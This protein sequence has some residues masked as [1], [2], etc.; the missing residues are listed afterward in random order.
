MVNKDISQLIKVITHRVRPDLADLLKYSTSTWVL[1]DYYCVDVYIFEITSPLSLY[2]QLATLSEVD[3]DFLLSAI[4]LVGSGRPSQ[5]RVA[6]I[7]HY[8]DLEFEEEQF[9]DNPELA[10]ISFPAI[11]EQIKK[12]KK[13]ITEGDYE[14]AITAAK[15]VVESICLFIIEA[16]TKERFDYKNDLPALHKKVAHILKMWPG[17]YLADKDQDLKKILS[18]AGTIIEAVCGIRNN[19]SDAHGKGPSKLNYNVDKRHA[20]LVVNLSLAIS[21]YLYETYLKS[22]RAG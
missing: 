4:Q 9:S 22:E 5:G 6:R 16:K 19:H 11:H 17:A 3:N 12:G 21:E 20:K 13:K 14:G 8:A 1:S 10:G 15:T 7:V 18:G 2:D